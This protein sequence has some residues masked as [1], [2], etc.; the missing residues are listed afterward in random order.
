MSKRGKREDGHG[1]IKGK[2]GD[3]KDKRR[4]KETW[5]VKK[6]MIKGRTYR[7]TNKKR[8]EVT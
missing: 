4:E 8:E 2:G 3:K 1:R 7:E 6:A 5:T